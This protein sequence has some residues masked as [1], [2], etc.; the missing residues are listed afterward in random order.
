MWRQLVKLLVVLLWSMCM[1]H[2][3]D[4]QIL[5]AVKYFLKRGEQNILLEKSDDFRTT[6]SNEFD[7][8]IVG[9]G[10]AGCTLAHRLSENPKWRVLLLEAGRQENLLMDIPLL[11]NFL[12]LNREVNWGYQPQSSN[13]SCLAMENNRCN[14]P[15]GRVM[16]GSS[17]LNYMIFTRGN[18]RD[19][20]KWAAMGNT[21]W[22]YDDVLP[23]FKKLE[24]SLVPN[25]ETELRGHDGHIA[26]SE[27]AWKSPSAEAFV[28]AA[29]ELG[30][31]YVDYNGRRQIGA[32]FL[33]TSTK[34]GARVSSNVGYLYPIKD[35]KNLII[36]KM[37][38]VTKVLI[39]P[40]TKTATGVVYTQ[41][42]KQY[43]VKARKEV[44]VSAGGIN[45]PQL[46][47][48]SGIGPAEHL[49]K[50]NIKT[51][52]DLPVGYNLM[53]HAAPGGLV[54]KV[55][56]S[57]LNIKSLNAQGFIDY[58]SGHGPLTSPGG[59][60]SLVFWDLE[61]QSDLDAWP[62][63]ELLQIGGAIHAFDVFRKNFGIRDDIW[64]PLF[65]PLEKKTVEAFTVF[66]MVL[67]PKSRGRI[68]L[69]SKNPYVYP[70]IYSNYFTDP[71]GYDL[72]VS[73]NGLKKVVEMLETDALQ[74]IGATL[75]RE[76]IPTCAHLGFGTDEYWACQAR[77]FTFTIYHYSG[78]C[79][80]GPAG[81]ET[82]V[83]DPRLRVHGVKRL[84]VVDASIF[85]EI[86]AGHPNGPVY[87][88]AEKA[89]DMIKEDWA[90]HQ[91]A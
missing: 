60:E 35:R 51:L 62:D 2:R 87:M 86:M 29:L 64:K 19:Y 37:S 31:P 89:A 14:W 70:K 43:T 56:V 73:V 53:D 10:T 32:S 49:K 21:G 83:V 77:H 45:S 23:Y 30:L 54:I 91:T 85:P 15:R 12:Q 9:A 8:I 39:D 76:P 63:I 4:A 50:F 65:A 40:E 3:G 16:G 52:S 17:V 1:V 84:R 80:M 57:T 27:V 68:L 78:T 36:R 11:V 24:N 81:D 5:D 59:C 90:H 41:K 55:N 34:D 47:M 13:T 75:H 38:H 79:K 66:P 61:N 67:R 44:I 25:E 48:L 22:S 42:K 58:Q 18:R 71:E 88:I 20:D 33:Q 28:Q 6:T 7:F 69:Q 26:V 72:Q 46:L 74:K 82:A